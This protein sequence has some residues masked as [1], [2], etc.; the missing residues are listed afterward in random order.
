MSPQRGRIGAA[1]AEGYDLET[2]AVAAINPVWSWKSPSIP[3]RQ[4]LGSSPEVRHG[5]DSLHRRRR[6]H[7]DRSQLLLLPTWRHDCRY[8]RRCQS[9]GRSCRCQHR[10][11]P[12]T[13]EPP[14]GPGRGAFVKRGAHREPQRGMKRR[15]DR[16]DATMPR[17]K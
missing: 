5:S 7:G 1:G 13:K 6:R 2:K 4:R 16:Q 3:M 11:G 15:S 9:G 10:A 14:Q 17:T 12:S 8:H